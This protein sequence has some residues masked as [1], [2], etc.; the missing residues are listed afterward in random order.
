MVATEDDTVGL[1]DSTPTSGFKCLSSLVDEQGGEVAAL[2]NLVGAANESARDDACLVEKVGVDFDF[3]LRL[4][5]TEFAYL[6]LFFERLAFVEALAKNFADAPKF[7]IVGVSGITALVGTF[8]HL[9]TH[10]ERVSDA[11]DVDP[12]ARKL[13]AYPIDGSV[14]GGADKHLSFPLER[15]DDGFDQSGG[16]ARSWRAVDDADLAGFKYLLNGSLLAGIEPRERRGGKRA[17]LWLDWAD[18]GFA[19]MNEVFVVGAGGLVEAFEHD[20][21]GSLVDGR[22]KTDELILADGFERHQCLT[23]G[24]LKVDKII[25]EELDEALE[26]EVL[27]TLVF[28]SEEDGGASWFET[29]GYVVVGEIFE[30]D[31]DDELV[32]SVAVGACQLDRV[33]AVAVGCATADVLRKRP[34]VSLAFALQFESHHFCE[35]SQVGNAVHESN[36]DES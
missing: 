36:N 16:F 24:K 1:E 21:V 4:A 26:G 9:V 35:V 14:A 18:E 28:E 6:G 3:Q 32:E 7:V 34:V 2:K 5:F 31:L 12:S 29:L 20:A 22:A 19:K 15:L 23:V 17:K 10:A 13:G 8:E 11:E 25:A 30:A 33:E 27:G